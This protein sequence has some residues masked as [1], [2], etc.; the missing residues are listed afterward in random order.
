MREYGY[1][2]L[3]YEW[4]FFIYFLFI[5]F[6][7]LTLNV[8]SILSIRPHALN[9]MHQIWPLELDH[10]D[11]PISIIV[12]A[13]NEELTIVGS[14]TA[15]LNVN[16]Y[17][18]EIIIVCDGSKDNTLGELKNN[19]HL[20]R[21]NDNFRNEVHN[22]PVLETY[23]SL[24]DSRIRVVYK[25]N[26]GKADAINC[27]INAS[28]Y[29]LFCCIDADTLLDP[30]CF[31]KMIKPFIF[32][33]ETVAVGGIVRIL[34]GLEIENGI[35]KKFHL[36]KKLI[37]MAQVVEYLRAFFFGRMGFMTTNS[38]LIISGAFGLFSRA[39]VVKVGGYTK[40]SLGEDMDLVLKIRQYYLE[41]KQKFK[42]EFLPDAISYT[43]APDDWKTLGHQRRRWQKGLL[44]C[45][46]RHKKLL[47]NPKSGYVG[48]FSYPFYVLA[49]AAGPTIEMFGYIG[50]I[51]L[52]ILGW[53][54]LYTAIYFYIFAVLLGLIISFTA[55]VIE[56]FYYDNFSFKYLLYMSLLFLL[57]T[58]I[59][60]YISV[61]WRVQGTYQ[62]FFKNNGHAWGD[63]TRKKIEINTTKS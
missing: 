58:M 28:Q 7:Y 6:G 61:Y 40:G 62:Y 4:T 34:N 56:D 35:V 3:A 10:H 9:K 53:I 27:G 57:E 43:Q 17:K 38:L 32:N 20:I 13:Y 41:K 46:I 12:P 8:L 31:N 48:F 63:M 47:L 42:I 45:L 59:Y 15:L 22:E 2:V 30:D 33:K 39:A 14:V 60:R 37:E 26:G 19:F 11:P 51:V 25:K 5:N 36:P 52:T 49:E 44:E 50:L 54:N 29:S 16:Y 21:S 1:L 18:Y 24:L 55:I 23:H